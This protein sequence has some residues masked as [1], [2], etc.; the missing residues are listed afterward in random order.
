MNNPRVL[1]DQ[2][3]LNE[4]LESVL[5]AEDLPIDGVVLLGDLG[6]GLAE[7]LTPDLARQ[8]LEES[9]SDCKFLV[10]VASTL[11]Y[12]PRYAH[13]GMVLERPPI[14]REVDL[15]SQAWR[16]LEDA[17]SAY[18]ESRQMDL[19]ILRSVPLIRPGASDYFSRYL[20]AGL[21]LT[22]AGYDPSL[23]FIDFKNWSRGISAALQAR[24]TGTFHLTCRG[25]LPLSRALKL[26]GSRKLALPTTL[27]QVARRLFRGKTSKAAAARLRFPWTVSG[28]TAARELGFEADKNAAEVVA[29]FAGRPG[30]PLAESEPYGQDREYI[31]RQPVIKYLHDSHWRV[32][33][34]GLE[35]IPKHGRALLVGVHRGFMPFDGTQMLLGVSRSTGR[36]PRFL[37]HP[38]LSKDPFLAAFITK[39]GG[40]PACRRNAA[41][42]L[43]QDELLGIFPEGI[44]GAFSYYKDAYSLRN[45]GRDEYVKI[46]L[47]HQAPIIP[48]VT[49]GS[50]E[51]FPVIAKFNW[52]FWQRQTDWPCFPIAPPFPFLPIPFPSKWHTRV[53]EPIPMTESADAVNDKKR[54]RA[55]GAE[56]EAR[57][58]KHM[59]EMRK[60]RKSIFYGSIFEKP[61]RPRARRP[62][63]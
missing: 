57:L 50:A 15:L 19:T 12:P 40:L 54:V 2:K 14:A 8:F 21:G 11:I 1:G 10:L 63:E 5:V 4:Q 30:S 9:A 53:L 61:E 31:D 33:Y 26:A 51:I 43:E 39:L 48:F 23:Q 46:A 37:V 34:E 62:E 44:H 16:A 59:D 38:S 25:S 60:N 20:A 35:H 45:F 47:L 18:C 7:P 32:E 58:L 28:E 24:R 49:V 13:P 29:E 6:L 36:Y 56:V 22:F 52:G 3:D 55:I 27:Q 42:V 41:Y 17:V